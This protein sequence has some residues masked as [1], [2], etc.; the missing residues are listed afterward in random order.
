MAEFIEGAI[1]KIESIIKHGKL[2]LK[3][4]KLKASVLKPLTDDIPDREREKICKKASDA[5]KGIV[6]TVKRKI[7]RDVRDDL[8]L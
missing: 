4:K 1:N 6:A 3:R 5:A 7:S 2:K 8:K